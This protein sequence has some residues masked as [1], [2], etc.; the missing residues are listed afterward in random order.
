LAQVYFGASS[1]RRLLEQGLIRGDPR[2][3]ALLDD[4]LRVAPLHLGLLN[5]F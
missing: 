3:A 5:G 2:A 1:A 4:A